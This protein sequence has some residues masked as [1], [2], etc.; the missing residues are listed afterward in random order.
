MITF[1]IGSPPAGT[2]AGGSSPEFQAKRRKTPS[3]WRRDEKRKAEFIKN[4]SLESK[5]Q[6]ADKQ[7]DTLGAVLIEPKDEILLEQPRV[8]KAEVEKVVNYVG[9]YIYDTKLQNDEI[10]KTI[11]KKLETNF[12]EGVEEFSEGSTCNEKLVVFWGKCKFKEGFN[13]KY[14]LDQKNWPAEMKKIEIEEPG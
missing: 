10:H 4:K 2:S 5:E 13:Q 12:K 9:E 14:L 1:K 8:K 7:S 3:N 6:V 11:W